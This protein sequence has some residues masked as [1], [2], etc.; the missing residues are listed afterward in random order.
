MAGHAGMD[1]LGCTI[2]GGITAV[3]GGT[4]RDLIIGQL[5]VFWIAEVEY[6]WLVLATTAATFI[7]FDCVPRESIWGEKGV[8]LYATDCIGLG[9]FAVIGAQN[10]IRLKLPSIVCVVCGMITAT[11][12]GVMRDVLCQKP[13][14]IIYSHSEI[15]AVTALSGAICYVGMRQLRFSPAVRIITG[16]LSA[17]VMRHS[18]TKYG[19]KLPVAS[20]HEKG[21]EQDNKVAFKMEV[22]KGDGKK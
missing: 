6:L 9:A 1:S 19:I 7:G 10:A 22:K 18:A 5:P 2:V 3:G 17:V 14:R 15:Y 13:A 21:K 4:V 12:G 16:V 20:W 11:F 8:I